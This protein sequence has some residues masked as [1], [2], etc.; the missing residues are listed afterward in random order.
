MQI[1]RGLE[2]RGPAR[3]DLIKIDASDPLEFDGNSEEKKGRTDMGGVR[4]GPALKESVMLWVSR[5][6]KKQSSRS[7]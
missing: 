4:N 2:P 6:R 1:L 7:E 3:T 5:G